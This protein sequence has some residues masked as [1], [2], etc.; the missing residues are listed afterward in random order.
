MIREDEYSDSYEDVL[1]SYGGDY[2]FSEE[3]YIIDSDSSRHNSFRNSD[4][5]FSALN[6]KLKDLGLQHLESPILD[7]DDRHL[8]K[9]SNHSRSYITPEESPLRNKTSNSDIKRQEHLRV[10]TRFDA[11]PESRTVKTFR[12]GEPRN[13]PS[14][15]GQ[16]TE[17]EQMNMHPNNSAS[18]LHRALSPQL[19]PTL[20]APSAQ[21]M[22]PNL[23]PV[24]YSGSNSQLQKIISE[25]ARK[26]QEAQSLFRSFAVKDDEKQPP[27]HVLLMHPTSV[28]PSEA[29]E[30][31]IPP[32]PSAEPDFEMLQRVGSKQFDRHHGQ[33]RPQPPQ[34]DTRMNSS[35]QRLDQRMNQMNSQRNPSPMINQSPMHQMNQ[36]QYPPRSNMQAE[37]SL[38][39]ISR[40]ERLAS[41]GIFDVNP[42]A[43]RKLTPN[44]VAQLPLQ[45]FATPYHEKPQYVVSDIDQITAPRLVSTSSRVQTV[46]ISEIKKDLIAAGRLVEDEIDLKKSNSKSKKKG[47]FKDKDEIPYY[48]EKEQGDR[49]KKGFFK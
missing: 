32:P 36:P 37:R 23:P 38:E 31:S 15:Y 33:T 49:E 2:D 27:E 4:A 44:Q 45:S 9:N 8:Y 17:V 34:I 46:P 43:S 30:F 13:N 3:E 41:L 14:P 22:M 40:N 24:G 35:P 18:S 10:D 16:N 48:K 25:A 1:D 20:P 7:M 12:I 28:T 19:T 26:Q 42:K 39:D 6:S 29:E 11:A 21:E 47:F 5:S